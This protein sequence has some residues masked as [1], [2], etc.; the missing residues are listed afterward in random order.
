LE[1]YFKEEVVMPTTHV[2]RRAATETRALVVDA[3]E[4]TPWEDARERLEAPEMYRTY[5]LTTLH[6]DGHP[7]AMPILGLWL[8]GIFYFLTSEQSRKGENLAG[9]GRCV[10]T[11]SITSL[12]ALDIS[13]E[14]A[15]ARVTDE[16][17]LRRVV[18]AYGSELHWPLELRDGRVVGANA[19]TAGPPPYAVWALTPNTVFGLPGVAGTDEQGR[20]ERAFVPTRWR[21]GD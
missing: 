14:G 9:D 4:P 16:A 21:F 12:P 1:T 8:D 20:A 10:L 6:A 3:G 17:S 15:A 2:E 5:W 18:D 19:P 11:V 13:A 7:H